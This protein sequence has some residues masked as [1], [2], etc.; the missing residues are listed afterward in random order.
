MLFS[1]SENEIFVF[2]GFAGHE[3]G[4]SWRFD[5][6]SRRWQ[7]IPSGP[8]TARSVAACANLNGRAV[9]FGGERDPSAEGHKGAGHMLNDVFI[10]DPKD[11]S[12]FKVECDGD[13]PCARGWMDWAPSGKDSL[14][15]VGGLSEQNE[16][17]ADVYLLQIHH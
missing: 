17:L 4:D 2:C 14:L 8:L 15:L 1:P 13:Q 5:V 3:L 6:A 16:R 9:I 12:W 7:S 10:F 11:G